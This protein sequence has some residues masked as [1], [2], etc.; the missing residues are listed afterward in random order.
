MSRAST[1]QPLSLSFVLCEDSFTNAAEEERDTND[2]STL[3]GRY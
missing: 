2:D 3:G 1:H